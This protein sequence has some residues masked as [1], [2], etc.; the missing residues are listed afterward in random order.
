V[1]RRTTLAAGLGTLL[2]AALAGP[3]VAPG[4]D[5]IDRPAARTSRP[6]ATPINALARAGRRLVAVGVRGLVIVSDDSGETWQQARVPVSCDLTA[7]QF[8]TPH[9][10]WAV[11]HDGVVLHSA[12]GGARW[13]RQLDGRATAQQLVAH[14]EVLAA[15][16]SGQ[17]TASL[18]AVR[19]NY[20]A[21]PEQALLGVCFQDA[22]RG[23]VC[24]SFGTLLGTQDGG[25]T[26]Q[27]WLERIDNPKQLHLNAI[28][29]IGGSVFIASEQGCVFRLE[30]AG[31]GSRFVPHAT[32]YGGS[33]FGVLGRGEDVMAYG[34]RGTAFLSRDAG[35]RWQRLPLGLD[36]GLNGGAVFDDGAMALVS[37][38]GRVLLSR[39]GGASFRPL[40]VPRPGLFTSIVQAAPG[41]AVVGG[42]AG[43]SRVALR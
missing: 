27:S 3:V 5:P 20:A 29:R 13:T 2:P 43:L 40:A 42:L 16:G 4:A 23:V 21:G 7:V 24:G 12:D 9:L 32:G 6:T 8:V 25:R 26:W 33:F 34:L 22:R 36:A 14:Y 37:Q 41:V 18:A 17:A 31:E 19:Q 39:D 11:G 28:E 35:G 1:H 38:D 30:G 10:G 15:K